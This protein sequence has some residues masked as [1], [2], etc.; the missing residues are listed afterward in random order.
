LV[1]FF[2]RDVLYTIWSSYMF[3]SLQGLS[4]V[5]AKTYKCNRLYQNLTEFAVLVCR[6]CGGLAPLILNLGIRW[7]CVVS[8]TSKLLYYRESS[9]V[10]IDWVAYWLLLW[11]RE[12]CVTLSRFEL[13]TVHSITIKY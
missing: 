8:L 9:V 6:V 10:S 12:K 2:T 3:R 7:C 11:R 1:F 5:Y 13:R 4:A